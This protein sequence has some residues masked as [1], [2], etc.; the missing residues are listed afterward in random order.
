MEAPI[1]AETII[2][3]EEHEGPG[4]LHL[5]WQRSWLWE[6]RTEFYWKVTGPEA[7]LT[8]EESCLPAWEQYSTPI[9]P[10]CFFAS[11]RFAGTSL[12]E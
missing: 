9:F 5:N 2:A 11:M 10:P 4:D 8:L 7:L 6:C 1:R 12:C 3:G